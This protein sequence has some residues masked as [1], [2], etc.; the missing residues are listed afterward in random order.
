MKN[1]KN[2]MLIFIFLLTIIITGFKA[3]DANTPVGNTKY[4]MSEIANI[5]K[6]FAY[7]QDNKGNA[8]MHHAPAALINQNTASENNYKMSIKA[9]TLVL[10]Y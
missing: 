10:G 1:L 5:S 3:S 2:F 9:K 7:V 6:K 8:V 4:S